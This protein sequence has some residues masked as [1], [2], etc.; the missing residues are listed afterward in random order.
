[1]KRRAELKN[2]AFL[3]S[4]IGPANSD[5]RKRA[6]TVCDR[7]IKPIVKE[8]NLTIIRSDRDPTPEW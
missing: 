3:I 1:M 4:Q 2:T 6:D 7:L 8:F 5:V